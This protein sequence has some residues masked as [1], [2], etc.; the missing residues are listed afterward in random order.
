MRFNYV[1]LISLFVGLLFVPAVSAEIIIDVEL[2]NYIDS[3]KSGDDWWFSGDRSA[4]G[5]ANQLLF[6][7]I[8]NFASLGYIIID[9]PG[10]QGKWADGTVLPTATRIT[11]TYTYDEYTKPVY[12]Y[13]ERDKDLLGTITDTRYTLFFQDWSNH[14]Q[15]GKKSVTINGV[16]LYSGEFLSASGSFNQIPWTESSPD[17][18]LYI[19][20]QGNWVYLPYNS[21]NPMWVMHASAIPWQHHI[22]VT[23]EPLGYEISLT[24]EYGSY[25]F[26]S[27]LNIYDADGVL[28]EGSLT[29]TDDV[30]W[31]P[32][33][34]NSAISVVDTQDNEYIYS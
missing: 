17:V 19:I 30:Y 16:T 1:L 14:N 24:K 31:K 32:K 3:S 13:V 15:N 9:L 28:Q 10:N 20:G 5:S 33:S 25:S 2:E 7:D 34:L 29:N 23:E 27:T 26:G 12:I 22:T 21:N 4:T 6:K 8:G 18:C 11:T